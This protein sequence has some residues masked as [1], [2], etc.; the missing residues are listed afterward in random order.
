M[1][2]YYLSLHPLIPWRQVKRPIEWAKRFGRTAPI[3]VE[4]G[5]GNGE[6][7]VRHALIHPQRDFIGIELEWASIQRCL[8]KIAQS[9]ITNIRLMQVNAHVAFARLFYPEMIERV[10]ALFPCP[11]PKERHAKHRLFSGAFLKLV[12]SR[13]TWQ[14]E[15][16]IV[17]DDD[18]YGSWVKQQS[19]DAGF[20]FDHHAVA[21]KFSTKYERKWQAQGQ[22]FFHD[23]RLSKQTPMSI[24]V[25]EDKELQ[26]HHVRTF[27]PEQFH[28]ANQQGEITIKFKDFIYDHKQMRAMQ[29]VYIS[30]DN[31][32]QDVWIDIAQGDDGWLIRPA[33]GCAFIP[34]KGLQQALDLIHQLISSQAHH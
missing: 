7:L 14:G 5:F 19:T 13:L 28:P 16:Q 10:F 11:W 20:V 2:A 22:Q 3:E 21:A 9:D 29:W 31:L 6:Y 33:R 23:L 25:Q 1:K 26:V 15:L 4:I 24:P 12:N 17:T 34:T 32:G 30:E 27:D 18:T 8:H